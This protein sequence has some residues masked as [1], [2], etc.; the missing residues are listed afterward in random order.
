[1]KWHPLCILF[2][3]AILLSFS[4]NAQKVSF[5]GYPDTHFKKIVSLDMDSNAFNALSLDISGRTVFWDLESKKP[6]RIWQHAGRGLMTKIIFD[7]FEAASVFLSS[8]LEG[9]DQV[10]IVRY[11]L[12][13]GLVADTISF[14][15]HEDLI[16]LDLSRGTQ[17]K[18]EAIFLSKSHITCV[19]LYRLKVKWR[20]EIQIEAS[21]I[22]YGHDNTILIHGVDGIYTIDESGESITPFIPSHI[23][24]FNANKVRSQFHIDINNGDL[25]IHDVSKPESAEPTRLSGVSNLQAGDQLDLIEAPGCKLVKIDRS[26]KTE[27]YKLDGYNNI[28]WSKEVAKS[29]EQSSALSSMKYAKEANYIAYL[30][31]KREIAFLGGNDGTIKTTIKNEVPDTRVVYT[32]TF[33]NY[34]IYSDLGDGDDGSGTSTSQAASYFVDMVFPSNPHRISDRIIKKAEFSQIVGGSEGFFV[35]D[36]KDFSFFDVGTGRMEVFDLNERLFHPLLGK[37]EDFDLSPTYLLIHSKPREIPLT[38]DVYDDDARPLMDGNTQ[39]GIYAE[40]EKIYGT[41]SRN[42]DGSHRVVLDREIFVLYDMFHNELIDVILPQEE[43]LKAQIKNDFYCSFTKSDRTQLLYDVMAR[44]F[45]DPYGHSTLTQVVEDKTEPQTL[46]RYLDKTC[47]IMNENYEMKRFV[48]DA[49]PVMLAFSSQTERVTFKKHDEP[50]NLYAYEYNEDETYEMEGVFCTKFEDISANGHFLAL[51]NTKAIQLINILDGTRVTDQVKEFEASPAFVRIFADRGMALS[52]RYSGRLQYWNLEKEEEHATFLLSPEGKYVAY[53]EDGKFDCHPDAMDEV[54]YTVRKEIVELEQLKEKF[55][56]PGFWVHLPEDNPRAEVLQ[57]KLSTIALYPD[58][59]LSTSEFQDELYI[60]L[61]P[62]SGGIGY[63]SFFINNVEIEENINPNFESEITVNLEDF[64]EYLIPDRP[65]ILG[66][67]VYNSANSGGPL[68]NILRERDDVNESGDKGW[69]KSR[70]KRIPIVFGK[71]KSAYSEG[72][73]KGGWDDEVQ[74]AQAQMLDIEKTRIIGFVIGTSDYQGGEIDLKYADND[75]NSM[76][77]ALHKTGVKFLED[78]N[79]VII[80]KLISRNQDPSKTSTREN[81]L[82]TMTKLENDIQVDDILVVFFSGH[83]LTYK[84]E[85]YYASKDANGD[86]LGDNPPASLIQSAT[87]SATEINDFLKKTKALRKLL[88]F[89]A[90]YSGSFTEALTKSGNSSQ[91][92]A[93]SKLKD[94]TGVY[95]L[96]SSMGSQKSVELPSLSQGVMTYSLLD[97]MSGKA[98]P[99]NVIEVTHLIEHVIDHVPPL[100]QQKGYVQQPVFMSPEASMSFAIGVS[101]ES[102][103]PS[104][105]KVQIGRSSVEDS[106]YTDYLLLNETLD[107]AIR[108]KSEQEANVPFMYNELVT[109]NN[110]VVKGDYRVEN[111]MIVLKA[112]LIRNNTALK[113]IKITKK[114]AQEVAEDLVNALSHYFKET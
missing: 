40:G 114:T 4:S 28:D 55:W 42:G 111:G 48:L 63:V 99:D 18:Q 17:R 95:V 88:I 44:I 107:E 108:K 49:I 34:M 32:S 45:V 46:L 65:N 13:D 9:T 109:K 112:A 1:M 51:S 68:G 78:E 5:N 8:S 69:L 102:V 12:F 71:Q 81:I 33:L 56:D 39:V 97:G 96:S 35:L 83:G 29:A 84:D 75:A 7:Q 36:N 67:V 11:D 64:K 16:A 66:V 74:K 21:D 41:C 94:K 92:K 100:A 20:I 50:E 76:E 3:V 62:N 79:K 52:A 47:L 91:R 43:N 23:P 14:D 19:D 101:D 30:T 6:L 59:A 57:E 15:L 26:N 27:L 85:Y 37:I 104:G 53:N 60:E 54:Y 2:S 87:I 89:D 38:I 90:C 106:I 86:V 70:Q 58:V 31:N 61:T 98:A 24:S 110:V 22:N 10:D 77:N 82:K 25:I 80:N 73:T 113:K 105:S 72:N 93:M 103:A